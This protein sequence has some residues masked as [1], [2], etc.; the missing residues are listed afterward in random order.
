M[1]AENENFVLHG[2]TELKSQF[3]KINLNPFLSKM[4]EGCN[5]NSG[6]YLFTTDTK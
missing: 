4:Y 3:C 5:F 2:N 1:V 6:N